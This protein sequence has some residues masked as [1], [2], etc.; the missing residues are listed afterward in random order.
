M[1]PSSGVYCPNLVSTFQRGARDATTRG[2]VSE[3]QRFISDY[4]DIEPEEIVTGF[5]GRITQGYVQRFQKEQ[6]LPTFGIVGSLTRAAIARVCGGGETKGG[7]LSV[8]PDSS[9][10]YTIVFTYNPGR[11]E[12][13]GPNFIDFGDGNTEPLSGICTLSI[14]GSCSWTAKH[15]Y[16]A[17]GTYTATVFQEIALGMPCNLN[18]SSSCK[19]TGRIV[20]A[21]ATVVVRGGPSTELFSASPLYGPVPLAVTFIAPGGMSCI[22]G[23]DYKIDF[24]DGSEHTMPSCNRG[25]HKVAHTYS[26]QG[27]YDAILFAI[28]AEN[29]PASEAYRFGPQKVAVLQIQAGVGTGACTKEY[30]PV[31]GRPAGCA[32][33]CTG[34]IC[35]MVDM[36]PAYC[37]LKEP[38][39]Y[40]N[41]CLLDAAG[42]T[43]LYEG[44]CRSGWKNPADDPQCKRWTDGKWCGSTCSRQSPGSSVIVCSIPS[45]ENLGRPVP[46]DRAPYCVEYFGTSLNQPPTINS[47]SGPTY[48]A[49]SE[50]GTWRIEA[51]DPENGTLSYSVDWGDQPV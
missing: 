1:P 47:F 16:K 12:T 36:A 20:R 46:P 27:T 34:R 37:A 49:V 19:S 21:T 51:S 4:Y 13:G 29:Y 43:S 33:T 15:T 28:P 18:D 7:T 31:C 23:S 14:P 44:Q 38:Q 17:A 48:L 30:V 42:A 2:Q 11:I 39:T 40:S 26:R 22:D 24:G 41:K 8:T 45:C 5:F 25:P 10:P 32:N 9:D 50:N 35:P 6:G 3:L